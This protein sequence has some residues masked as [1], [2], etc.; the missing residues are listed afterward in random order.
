MDDEY[1]ADSAYYDEIV[2]QASKE[3]VASFTFDRL[4]AVYDKEPAI[5]EKAFGAL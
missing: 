2:E 1:F 4:R 3:A 5:A